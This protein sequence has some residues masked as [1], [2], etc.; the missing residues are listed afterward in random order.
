MIYEAMPLAPQLLVH[1]QTRPGGGVWK[2]Q[3]F[4]RLSREFGVR[5]E[6]LPDF[7]ATA[8]EMEGWK[9]L[10]LLF[11]IR[12]VIVPLN[13]QAKFLRVWTQAALSRHL[14]LREQK[15]GAMIYEIKA[16][17]VRRMEKLA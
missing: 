2:V 15:I 17:W 6:L 8:A 1:Y 7:H 3:D 12:Q 16:T 9:S 4:D 14:G 11:G 5:E 13:T 10:R